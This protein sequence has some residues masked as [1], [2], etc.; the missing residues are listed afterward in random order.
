MAWRAQ[1]QNRASQTTDGAHVGA[2]DLFDSL[3]APG[4]NIVAIKSTIW[5]S[6]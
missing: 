4:D 1:Q 6:R 5:F 2:G 3:S